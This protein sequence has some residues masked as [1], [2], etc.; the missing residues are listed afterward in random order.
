VLI[1]YSEVIGANDAGIYAG[2]S[3]DVIVR[4]NEVHENVLGIELENTINGEVYGNHTYGNTCG[5]L[6]VLLPH[7]ESKVSLHTKV[8][9]RFTSLERPHARPS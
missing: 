1:E 7:L 3:A 5:I 2:Q 6:I 4:Y 8:N 9:H